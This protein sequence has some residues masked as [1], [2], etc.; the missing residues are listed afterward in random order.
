[1]TGPE[2]RARINVWTIAGV[3]GILGAGVSV[4][5]NRAQIERNRDEVA[6]LYADRVQFRIDL[7]QRLDD[8]LAVIQTQLAEAIRRLDRIERRQ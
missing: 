5:L 6:R 2:L 7:M 1:M 8:R 4:G 3:L